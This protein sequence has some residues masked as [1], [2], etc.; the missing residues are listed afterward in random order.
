VAERSVERC[1]A[2]RLVVL[3]RGTHW[4][5]VEDADEVNRLV[6]AFLEES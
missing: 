4:L 1:D 3:E 6:Q 2:G 5:P